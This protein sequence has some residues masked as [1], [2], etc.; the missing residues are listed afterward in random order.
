MLGCRKLLW[1]S[2][3]LRTRLSSLP[4]RISCLYR[5]FNAQINPELRSL[6]R[7]TRPNLPLPKGRPISN[8]PRCHTFGA[9]GCSYVGYELHS[10]LAESSWPRTESNAASRGGDLDLFGT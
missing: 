1:I 2:I 7:Y 8:M 9:A 5:T 6:T 10:I 3:S 4:C